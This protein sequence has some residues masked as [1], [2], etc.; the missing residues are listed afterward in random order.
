MLLTYLP[1]FIL[2]CLALLF[3]LASILVT[4]SLGPKVYH[5]S[6]LEPYECGVP[7]VGSSRKGFA[8]RFYKIAILF[9]LFDVEAALLFPWAVM[10][11]DKLPSWGSLFLL[12]EF[13]VFLVILM[14]GYV[15]AWKRGALEWE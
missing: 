3:P 7:A 10:F 11:K 13:A 4:S 1:I 6:K 15:Y 2:L 5:K 14:G 8:V 9:L 12:G